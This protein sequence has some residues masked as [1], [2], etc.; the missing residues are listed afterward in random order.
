MNICTSE[1]SATTAHRKSTEAMAAKTMVLAC[2]KMVWIILSKITVAEANSIPRWL[3]VIGGTGTLAIEIP[4]RGRTT[5]F[6]NSA[7]SRSTMN[8]QYSATREL[9]KTLVTFSGEF[10]GRSCLTH[11]SSAS[12]HPVTRG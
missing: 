3:N 10:W 6:H 12:S 2:V 4:R 9:T 11:A 5:A 1:V 8:K 7:A